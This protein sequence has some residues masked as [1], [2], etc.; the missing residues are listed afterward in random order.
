M[1]LLTRLLFVIGLPLSSFAEVHTSKLHSFKV[2][3]IENFK[4]IIWGFDFLSKDTLAL[5]LRSGKMVTYNLTTKKITE[6]KAPPTVFSRGQGGLLDIRVYPAF[7]NEVYFTY[8]E[9][10]PNKMAVT[11]LGYGKIEGGELKG[12]KKLFESSHPTKETIHFGSRIEFDNSGHLFVTIGD[13]NE[14]A[15]VQNMNSTIGK[16]IRLKLDGSI[17]NDNPFINQAGSRPEI[18]TLGHRSPQGLV[19]HPLTGALW[20]TEMGPRGGDELNLIQKGLNYGWPDVTLG[21]EYWGPKIGVTSKKNNQ[22]PVV[23]WSPSISPSGTTFYTGEIFTK[24][25][26]HL[27]IGTLSGMQL[28]RIHLNGDKVV[29]Q[30]VLLKDQGWRI[31]NVRTGPD[32]YLYLSTDHGQLARLEPAPTK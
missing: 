27:F 29:E 28:R 14:R 18:W 16:I 22:D 5:S 12:F 2:Q 21:R 19:R 20:Q 13:R 24:W 26:H 17:P 8:A 31:R 3:N 32:G 11:S 30:E 25:K 23:S 4:E 9:P 7:S 10:K 1:N 6:I 15:L